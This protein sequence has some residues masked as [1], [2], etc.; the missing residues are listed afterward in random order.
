MKKD[1]SYRLKRELGM[2]QKEFNVPRFDV[3]R[4]TAIVGW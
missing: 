1:Y 3:E 4:R 2:L